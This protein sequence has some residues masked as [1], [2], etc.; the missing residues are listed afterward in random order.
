MATP[1]KTDPDA[2][3]GGSTSGGKRKPASIRIAQR[4]IRLAERDLKEAKDGGSATAI[5]LAEERLKEA[6]QALNTIRKAAPGEE[7]K[8]ARRD[9]MEDYYERLGP[10]AASLAKRDPELR[11]LFDEAIRKG[12]DEAEFISNLKKTDWWNDPKKG[13]SWR[14][15]FD[16]EFN[17]SPGQWQE[18]LDDAK[19]KIRDM[20]NKMFNIVI[21]E[22]VLDKIARRYYYQG[23]GKDG[24]R[25]LRVWLSSQ[26]DKQAA[27]PDANLTTGG[28]LAD[29]ER[30]LRDA[31]RNFGVYRPND[32][33]TNTA[34]NIL[35][36]NSGFD[37]DDAWNELI[38]EAESL[39]PVFQ[40]KLSKDR[41]VR[42]VG[43][44]YFAQLARFLE[45]ND[46]ELIELD[47]PLLQ[48]AFQN[49]DEN[50]KQPGLMPLWQFTQEIK[51]DARWQYTS[52]ALNTYSQIGSDMARMMGFVG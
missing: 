39:Y 42:D 43:A 4:D 12:W 45:I 7:R 30:A 9:F 31:A 14:Q 23:W 2:P 26:F 40:G 10:E 22:D 34:K 13:N 35:N 49:I 6:R 1:P 44:G 3:S 19:T 15:A 41:S 36:P 27:A 47:D 25:G 21:P 20:A 5:R 52:N 24:E 33:F 32:W 28:L 50:T 29:Q 38:A 51:K 11:K 37:E 48:R 17:T 46:P 18:S 16:M 8:E